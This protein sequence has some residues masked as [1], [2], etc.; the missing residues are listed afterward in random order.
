MEN[1]RYKNLRTGIF[2]SGRRYFCALELALEL[3]GGKWKP[4]MLYHLKNG[5]LRSSELQKRLNNISNKMFTQTARE[6]ERDGLIRREV[7]PVSPPKVEYSL[8][9]MGD[10]VIPLIMHMGYWGESIGEYDDQSNPS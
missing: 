5:P 8:T 7:F 6:L 4:M 2:F 3:I 1:E 10:S 9:P